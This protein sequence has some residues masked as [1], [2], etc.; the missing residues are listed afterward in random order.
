MSSQEPPG[1]IT[2]T[3][4]N[5]PSV[6]ASSRGG[7]VSCKP[8]PVWRR[9][10]SGHTLS[11]LDCLIRLQCLV[12]TAV[13]LLI[14]AAGCLLSSPSPPIL[15]LPSASPPDSRAEWQCH[16]P[17]PSSLSSPLPPVLSPVSPAPSF[18]SLSQSCSPLPFTSSLLQHSALAG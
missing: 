6:L 9:G 13:S 2:Q 15:S 12:A 7:P 1:G 10:N 3:A 5:S 17:Q 18:A 11:R 16:G 8:Q 4:A 14:P